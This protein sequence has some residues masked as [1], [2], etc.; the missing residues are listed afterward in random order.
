MTPV[1][2]SDILLDSL[3]SSLPPSF[4]NDWKV[5]NLLLRWR[6]AV[7]SLPMPRMEVAE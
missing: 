1:Q 6:E 3:G 2:A 4:P 7:E 5:E